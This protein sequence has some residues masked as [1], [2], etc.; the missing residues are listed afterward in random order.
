MYDPPEPKRV[1]KLVESV[2][3]EINRQKPGWIADGGLWA[4]SHDG[5]TGKK[6]E[7]FVNFIA[8]HNDGR[9]V[10]LDTK[11]AGWL[12]KSAQQT[13]DWLEDHIVCIVF[14]H[15]KA[16]ILNSMILKQILIGAGVI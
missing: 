15:S 5:A 14:K 11:E 1:A 13:A 3:A 12:S 9:V 16:Q 10:N 4:I 6:A 8:W 7:Q 2:D